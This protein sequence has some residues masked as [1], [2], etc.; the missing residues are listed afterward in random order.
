MPRMCPFVCGRECHKQQ[1]CCPEC[2]KR[3]SRP[4]RDTVYT[5]YRMWQAKEITV[6]E[7]HR[8]QEAALIPKT[9]EE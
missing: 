4:D 7:M 5:L 3:L 9:Q 6:E 8:R 2:Y 1:F